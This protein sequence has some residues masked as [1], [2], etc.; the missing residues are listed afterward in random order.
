MGSRS[1]PGTPTWTTASSIADTVVAPS[2]FDAVRPELVKLEALL[3]DGQGIEIEA[4]SSLLQSIFD[5]GG[6]RIR[7]ALVFLTA[8][9][10]EVDPTTILRLAAAIE[11]LHTATLIHDDLVD[12][13]LLR[14]GA[15]TLNE[16]W[17]AG[18]TVLAGDWL[19][20]RSARFATEA[21]SL[22]VMEVFARTLS[23]LTEGEL[24]QHAD[25]S[26]IPTR[27]QYDQ[28]IYAK[29]ASLFEAATESTGI[30][31]ELPQASVSALADYG[32]AVGKAFQVI[33]D[34]LDFTGEANRMGKEVGSD[35]RSGQVTLPVMLHLERHPHAAPWLRAAEAHGSGA[36]S[37]ESIRESEAEVAVAVGRAGGD[38]AVGRADVDRGELGRDAG[39]RA[40][41]D[42]LI[43][44]VR[45]DEQALRGTRATAHELV[46]EA[47]AALDALPASE[48]RDRLAA[49]AE[50]TVARDA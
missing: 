41:I 8:G 12:G 44:A 27:E 6:K 10:G 40:D 43:E 21:G 39:A 37:N 7:P 46:A 22:R 3:S 19:F 28:R 36:P 35:L 23:A 15:P 24:R 18:A 13:S 26:G 42:A 33:D 16:R 49:I 32:R 45:A 17:S 34:L 25:R 1:A 11:T 20:A 48:A 9:L 29:T 14:R 5:S 30:L 50:F 31:L 4:V 47:I 38:S 2:P